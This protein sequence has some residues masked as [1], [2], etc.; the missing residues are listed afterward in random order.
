MF[1]VELIYKA[2]LADLDAAMPA[3]VTFLK[4]HYDAGHF[5]ISGRKVPRDGGVIVAAGI[6]REQLDLVMRADRSANAASRTSESSNSARA[7]APATSSSESTRR[8]SAHRNGADKEKD[9]CSSHT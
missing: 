3:H 7:S 4:K 1:V 6:D 8:H 9:S 5:L 2:A